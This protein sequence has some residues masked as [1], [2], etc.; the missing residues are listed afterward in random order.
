MKEKKKKRKEIKQEKL[1]VFSKHV[2][3]ENASVKQNDVEHIV[4]SRR[5]FQ[6][7]RVVE[8]VGSYCSNCEG[9]ERKLV[10]P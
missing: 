3:T 1:Y 10:S 2:L 6:V 5:H 7:P 4:R 9:T 8:G